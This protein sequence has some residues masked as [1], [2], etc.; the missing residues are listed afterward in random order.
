MLMFRLQDVLHLQPGEDVRAM[1][2]RHGVTLSFP[3]LFAGLLIVLPFF[4]LFMLSRAGIIGYA[5]FGLSIVAGGLFAW[6]S[7][8]LWDADVF[9][10]TTHR[11]MDV[12]QR[13]VWHRVVTETPLQSVEDVRWERRGPSETLFRLGT[14]FI[15]RQGIASEIVANKLAHPERIL[16]LIHELRDATRARTM[17]SDVVVSTHSAKREQLER[18]LEN[19]DDRTLDAIASVLEERIEEDQESSL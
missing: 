12:D 4:F 7:F 1:H 14:I 17:S 15:R 2:R 18:L 8:H 6:R 13:G 19:A 10:V 16:S 3:L 9:V 11:V 5:L